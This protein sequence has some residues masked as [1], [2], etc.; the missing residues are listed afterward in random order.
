[1]GILL[2]ERNKLIHVGY[3]G[4]FKCMHCS[5][6]LGVLERGELVFMEQMLCTCSCSLG[7]FSLFTRH[8]YSAFYV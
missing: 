1:M 8:L 6:T 4:I 7:F 5:L 3:E 2:R